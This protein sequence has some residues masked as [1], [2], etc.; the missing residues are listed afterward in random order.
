MPQPEL[1]YEGM[2]VSQLEDLMMDASPEQEQLIV[3]ELVSRGAVTKTCLKCGEAI[4]H[5]LWC[6]KHEYLMIGSVYKR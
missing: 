4:G 1:A 5:G 6:K 2:S 3:D